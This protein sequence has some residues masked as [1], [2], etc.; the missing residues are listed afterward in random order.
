MYNHVRTC[1]TVAVTLVYVM[2]FASVQY[3][4]TNAQTLF[5]HQG[6]ALTRKLVESSSTLISEIPCTQ[7]V[8]NHSFFSGLG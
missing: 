3:A 4:H 1:R 2:G 6:V 8:S 7:N 5:F